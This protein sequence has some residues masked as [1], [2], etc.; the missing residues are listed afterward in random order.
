MSKYVGSEE[1]KNNWEC[2]NKDKPN[3]KMLKSKQRP[4]NI[5][6]LLHILFILFV[7]SKCNLTTKTIIIHT[8]NALTVTNEALD[9]LEHKPNNAEANYN[10]SN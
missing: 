2:N 9:E 10:T 6:K 1:G 4:P 7:A 8:M 5:K 3:R